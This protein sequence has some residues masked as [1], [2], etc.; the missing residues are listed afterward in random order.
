MNRQNR[1]FTRQI[2]WIEARMPRL[3]GTLKALVQPRR[4]WLRLPAALVLIFGGLL[5]VL[6]VLGFWM[7][8][9]GVLLLAIDLPRLRPLVGA[10]FVRARAFWR[11]WRR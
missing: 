1:R 6:P 11:R 4:V 5:G 7:L 3:G 2:T 8:P 9:L 10:T